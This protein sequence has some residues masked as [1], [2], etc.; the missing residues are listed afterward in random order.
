MRYQSLNPATEELIQ[1]YPELSWG[2]VETEAKR[3]QEAFQAWRETS[4]AERRELFL[5]LAE[6]LKAETNRLA[7]I[8]TQE[9]GKP[10]LEAETEIEKCALGCAFYAEHAESSLREEITPSDAGKSYV[11]YD[12]LGLILAIMPWNFP[13]WQVF[14]CSVP[15]LMAGNAVL[16]KHAPNVPRCAI[17]IEELFKAAGFP[18]DVFKSIFCSNETVARLIESPL[19]QGVSLTGSDRAGSQVA[20]VAGRAL[21]K[22]VLE[23]GGSDPFVVL[24]DADLEKCIPLA[25]RARMLNA[26]QSCIAAKRF[27]LT[28]KIASA[29]ESAF[30][31]AVGDQKVGDPM[32]RSTKIG[33]LARE[34]LLQNLVRQVE[35]SRHQGAVCLTGGGRLSR[36]GFFYPPTVLK[37]VRPGMAVFTEETFGPVASLMVVQDEAEAIALAN[38]TCYGLGASLWTRDIPRAERLAKKI[39]AGSVFI[40]G[41]TKSDPR[42]PF[43][44][45]KRSGYGRELSVF[46]LREFTNVKTVWIA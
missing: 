40:N 17:S 45:I 35:E 37:E 1:T 46:G 31:K 9:M 44:G 12:P 32:D 27:I 8:I 13:F 4:F 6:K 23:L 19:V 15:A 39:E 7:P 33:P 42:L 29:F 38:R 21:K 34:D 5:K 24:E 2:Q 43:G 14:R 30:L 28:K 41:M 22:T 3:G 36:K 18:R 16:L 10:I 25:I 26:G 20:A 11:R